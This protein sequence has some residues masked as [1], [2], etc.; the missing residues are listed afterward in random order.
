MTVPQRLRCQ[1]TM[2]NERSNA[3]KAP[4]AIG[5]VAGVIIGSGWSA[6]K[7]EATLFRLSSPAFAV[8]MSGDLEGIGC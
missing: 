3:C 4:S 6:V 2:G 5:F 8:M 1:G 7:H